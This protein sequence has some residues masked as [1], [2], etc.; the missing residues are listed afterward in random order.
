[1]LFFSLSAP[2]LFI[3]IALPKIR[4][5][6]SRKN[7]K[8]FNNL[9]NIRF[10][11]AL[12]FLLAPII[13]FFS[14]K[15]IDINQYDNINKFLLTIERIAG[16]IIIIYIPVL[17]NKLLSAVSL[18]FKSHDLF[19]RYPVNTYLQLLKLTIFIVSVV[20]AICY[21]L[22]T[23][24]WGVLSGIGALGAILLLVFKDTILGLVASIQVYGGNLIK[25]GDWIELKNMNIDGE[26]LE[27][28]LHRVKVKAWDNSITTFPTSKLLELTFKN[29]RNMK[30][31]GGRRI[32]R[33][34]IIKTSSIKFADADLINRMS[35]I[36]ILKEYIENKASEIETENNKNKSVSRKLT[37]VGC[38]RIYIKKYLE[39]SK[40]I[41]KNMTLMVRQKPLIQYGLPIEIYAFTNT[42]VWQDYE[43]IQSDIFDHILA[44][45]E[46]FEL[47]VYQSP[48][49]YDL[50]NYLISKKVR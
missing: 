20:L 42:T 33:D 36:Q 11:Y 50:N 44:S 9:I 1:M 43:D 15:N 32:K 25:E 10:F 28:G 37:N 39:N 27:V 34:I 7:K 26:V 40:Y 46:L 8:I 3:K 35:E 12:S 41:N 29:W 30:E 14:L 24:P 31:S 23:S 5:V 45:V 47:S 19:I 17:L 22:N 49:S 13:I 21:L 38:F 48:S 4:K 16:F 18:S 2:F 6:I